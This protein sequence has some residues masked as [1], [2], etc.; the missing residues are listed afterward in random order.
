MN[1]IETDKVELKRILSDT[2]EK[3]VVAFFNTDGGTFYI[4]VE[5]NGVVYGIESNK[6]DETMKKISDTISVGILPNPQELVNVLAKLEEGKWI[7][8]VCVNKGKFGRSSKGCYIRVVTSYRSMIEEQIEREYIKT[9]RIP[10]ITIVEMK[11][12]RQDLTFDEFKTILSYKHIHYNEQSFNRNF[13]LKNDDKYN[14][15]AYL[16]SEQN[17]ISIKAYKFKGTTKVDFLS[18]KEFDDGCILRKMEEAFD[19]A[20]NV[21]NLIQ[22]DVSGGINRIDTPLLDKY[23]FE[24][25]RYNEVYHNLWTSKIPPAIYGFED[26]VEII[27]Q[28]VLRDDLTEEEFFNGVS[29]PVNEELANIFLKLKY[30]EQSGKGISTIISKYGRD[31]FHFGSS[32][33]ECILPFNILIKK[34][35]FN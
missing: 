2:F 16:L 20:D 27:S 14:Y 25:A 28:R 11:S 19:Y 35:I 12:P 33:I 26:R 13:H 32:F 6:L 8:E 30:M 4:G 21:I 34:S 18:R 3:K 15:I 7:I 24:E 31:V 10:K 9:L 22:T 17:S 5:D 1:Y 29:K 23:S